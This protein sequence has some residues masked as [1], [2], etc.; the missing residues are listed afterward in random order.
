MKRIAT[1]LLSLTLICSFDLN[2]FAQKDPGEDIFLVLPSQSIAQFLI[3]LLP[4]QINMG[5]DFS[6]AMWLKSIKNFK[7]EKN[8]ISFSSHLYGKDILYSAK[9][10]KQ[11][12]NI[13]LGDIDLLNDWECNFRF[14]ANRKI[15][16]L[17]PHLKN[18]VGTKKES[19]KGSI[20]NILFK[21]LS[22]TEYPINLQEINPITAEF[23]GNSLT[24]NFSISDMYAVDNNLTLKIR[25][26]P[27]KN[28]KIKTPADKT[29]LKK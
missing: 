15:L 12:S 6:G 29:S 25:P 18:Q 24:I 4:Y 20:I 19:Q 23:L 21:A 16:F 3:K 26:I 17:N 7:I 22:D 5:K 10:G 11:K 13:A 28:D 8:K 1:I 14:E 2:T 27:Q 9:I